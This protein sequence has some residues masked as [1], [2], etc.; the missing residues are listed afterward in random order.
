VQPQTKKTGPKKDGEQGEPGKK[1]AK[2]K[3]KGGVQEW[4]GG[5][6]VIG[7]IQV[8]VPNRKKGL[9]EG[10]SLGRVWGDRTQ[11]KGKGKRD[12][13]Q[14]KVPEQE[15]LVGERTAKKHWVALELRYRSTTS[16]PSIGERTLRRG[17]VGGDRPIA[18][19]NLRACRSRKTGQKL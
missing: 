5:D 13:R 10:I 9:C 18:E 19:K 16:N 11:G 12:A 15:K 17:R 8:D 4:G 7:G 1:I 14:S 6:H 3:Q 2:N